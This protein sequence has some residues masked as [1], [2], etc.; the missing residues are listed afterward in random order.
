VLEGDALV[1]LREIEGPV[2]LLFLDGWKDLYLDVLALVRPKLRKGAIVV[3][4]NVNLADA[5][6][7][8]RHVRTP[9]N[10]FVSTTLFGGEMELSCFLG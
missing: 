7:Y 8:A 10:G 3:G 2:D 6:P 1:T 5:E 4:D 9:D